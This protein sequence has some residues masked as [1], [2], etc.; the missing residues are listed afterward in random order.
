M[1]LIEGYLVLQRLPKCQF[2]LVYEVRTCEVIDDP[3]RT[4]IS[5]PCYSVIPVC[6]MNGRIHVIKG[7]AV[8]TIVYGVDLS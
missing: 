5:P 1:V 2:S 8:Q 6:P 3:L 7:S 4:E